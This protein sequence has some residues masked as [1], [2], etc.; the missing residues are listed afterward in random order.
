MLAFTLSNDRAILTGAGCFRTVKEGLTSFRLLLRR[1]R[2]ARLRDGHRS[3]LLAGGIVVVISLIRADSPR[4]FFIIR[5][6]FFR[7][8]GFGGDMR[9]TMCHVVT[10]YQVFLLRDLWGYFYQGMTILLRGSDGS[11]F[12][13]LDMFVAILFWSLR[14]GY[15]NVC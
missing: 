2:Q 6:Y 15:C 9:V 8:S 10:R 13:F 4:G 5:F 14:Y 7:S 3:T 1:V 12:S 11:V